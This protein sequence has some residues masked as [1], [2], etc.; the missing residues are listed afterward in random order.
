[1]DQE[2]VDE[3]VGAIGQLILD[4]P[5]VAGNDWDSVTF[6]AVLDEPASIYGF[7]YLRDEV[8][9]TTPLT[10]DM[11]SLL[12]EFQAATADRDG[13]TWKACIVQI[14]GE[15]LNFQIDFEREDVGRLR[16]SPENYH[17]LPQLLKPKTDDR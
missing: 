13:S 14:H 4:D 9:P 1:M 2:K 5:E 12:R 8:S 3:L 7:R 11:I 16:I 6:V 10:I 17:K 15:D